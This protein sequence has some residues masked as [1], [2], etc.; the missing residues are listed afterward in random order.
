[1]SAYRTVEQMLEKID[2]PNRS[3]CQRIL[4][5]NRKLFEQIQGSTHNHQAWPGGGTSTTSRRS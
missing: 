2:E 5:D 1:M 4:V 3:A